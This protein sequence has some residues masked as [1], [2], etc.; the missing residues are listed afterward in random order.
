MP[1]LRSNL[2][3]LLTAL[4]MIMH[5]QTAV[6]LQESHLELKR[7]LAVWITHS[8]SNE[9]QS[10]AEELMMFDIGVARV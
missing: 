10:S 9:N 4:S 7:P 3:T 6:M 5:P 8:G 1:E 2:V